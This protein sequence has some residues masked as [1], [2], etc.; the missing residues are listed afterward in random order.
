ME[1]KLESGDTIVMVTDGVTEAAPC[2][3]GKENWLA[4]LIDKNSALS[5]EKL[6]EKILDEAEAASG[7]V[8][9]DDMTVL[10]ARIWKV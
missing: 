6:C 4:R 5:P 7:G 3:I 9:K 2:A 1:L 8:I 10:A